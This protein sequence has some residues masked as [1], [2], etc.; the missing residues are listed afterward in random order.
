MRDISWSKKEKEIA[1]RAFDNAYRKECTTLVNRAKKM[2]DSIN[3]PLDIWKIHDLLTESRKEIDL[4][5][6]YRYSV[7]ISV[8]ARLLRE[9]WLTDTDLAGLREDKLERVKALSKII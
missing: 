6:D 8:F 5:Y 7:L 2:L 9:G 1:R 4:K 3:D